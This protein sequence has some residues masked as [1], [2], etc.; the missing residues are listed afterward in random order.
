ML[1]VLSLV[2]EGLTTREIGVELG[3]SPHTVASYMKLLRR[4]F[5]ARSMAAAVAQ[6]YEWGLLPLAD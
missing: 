1:R 2:S 4:R 3:V 6:G 5:G